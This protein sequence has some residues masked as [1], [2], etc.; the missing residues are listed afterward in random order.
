MRPRK[1]LR[2]KETWDKLACGRTKFL[3]CYRLHHSNDPF[4][5]ET[6]IPRLKPIPLGKRALG[7]LEHEVDDLVEALASLRFALPARAP[8]PAAQRRPAANPAGEA[9]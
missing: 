2:P 5:P 4:V 3:E 1:I 6:Q 9:A 8:R 7:F